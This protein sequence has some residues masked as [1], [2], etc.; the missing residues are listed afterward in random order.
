MAKQRI[1][2]RKV[3]ELLRL[4]FERGIISVRELS[5]L[6]NVGKSTVSDYLNGFKCK[7]RSHPDTHSGNIRAGIPVTSGHPFWNYPDS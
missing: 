6:S 1:D 3:R 4:H 5:K 2:M 7:I